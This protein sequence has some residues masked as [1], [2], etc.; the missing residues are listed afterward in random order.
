[1]ATYRVNTKD[2]KQ[3]TKIEAKEHPTMAESTARRTAR[4]HLQR[5]GPGY[6]RAEKVNEKVVQNINNRMGAKPIRHHRPQPR[7]AVMSWF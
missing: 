3:G 1:M 5:Y 2:L 6:Y 4:Q 7:P